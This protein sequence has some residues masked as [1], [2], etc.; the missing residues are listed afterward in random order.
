M[1][2]TCLLMVVAVGAAKG[3][4]AA[5]PFIRVFI[6]AGHG[7]PGNDGNHGAYCQ[8]EKDHTLAVA[9]QLA[10]ALPALGRFE[11]KLSRTGSARPAYQT[12]I[13]MA[14]AWKADAVISIH[15]DV[16]GTAWPWQPFEGQPTTC[17]RSGLAPGFAVLWNETSG[18]EAIV[19]KRAA[20]GGAV[21]AAMQQAHFAVYGGEDYSA[22]YRPSITPGGWIDVRADGQN[23]YFL[24][25]SKTVPTVII[26]THHALD[27]SE[28]ALWQQPATLNA[29]AKA[30]AT[31]IERFI[32]STAA[33]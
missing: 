28:V 23:V 21:S 29:F 9:A 19:S 32:A 3:T 10:K 6:D 5:P 7:A 25:A 27:V 16:R 14:E 15:S 11:T 12:R 18:L 1:T 2:P 17:Y 24:R 22:L 8:L 26:E 30:L 20:L 4:P 13:A 31:A 33:P